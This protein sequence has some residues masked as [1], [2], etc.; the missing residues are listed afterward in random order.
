MKE[1]SAP[2]S[3]TKNGSNNNRK[4]N[5]RSGNRTSPQKDRSPQRREKSKS[6][7]NAQSTKS[8]ANFQQPSPKLHEM[9]L[10]SIPSFSFPTSSVDDPM[11]LYD[12]EI[13][14]TPE[15]ILSLKPPLSP[16]KETKFHS[17]PVKQ[18]PVSDEKPTL[19]S[20]AV[21]I[22]EL[23]T[24]KDN[25]VRLGQ[26][27]KKVAEAQVATSAP[28]EIPEK[29]KSMSTSPVASPSS[30]IFR[31]PS[32]PTRDTNVPLNSSERF[33]GP[34]FC[35]SPAPQNLPIPAFVDIPVQQP[36]PASRKHK[37]QSLN[38]VN[39]KGVKPTRLNFSPKKEKEAAPQLQNPRPTHITQH[40]VTKL[41]QTTEQAYA[42]QPNNNYL[43]QLSHQLQSMLN[44]PV[45][46]C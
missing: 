16:T 14:L 38:Q 17:S 1:L 5:S 12:E 45:Q 36:A 46:S 32:P 4:V 11:F 8:T 3:P 18:V 43:D 25:V 9:S 6:L 10:E 21:D 2:T 27:A 35:N 29:K 26:A 42:V 33:A 44:I 30:T 37:S 23:L 22:L 41:L 24:R 28:I 7:N 34:G 40:D 39:S 15:N 19:S 20:E 31:S 13:L